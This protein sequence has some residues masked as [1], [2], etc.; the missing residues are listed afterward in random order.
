[1]ANFTSVYFLEALAQKQIDL[2]T[3][4][5]GVL[6]AGA[7]CSVTDTNKFISDVTTLAELSGTGYTRQTFTG[8]P[9]VV[10]TVNKRVYL[11]ASNIDWASVDATPDAAMAIFYKDG[12]GDSS[13]L[14]VGRVDSGGFPRSLAGGVPV[15][16]RPNSTYGFFLLKGG[17]V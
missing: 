2:D 3:D 16:L 4:T 13:R 10:D 5:F 14:I 7:T 6:L 17:T 12:A 1:M 8:L 11:T 15:S 9:L